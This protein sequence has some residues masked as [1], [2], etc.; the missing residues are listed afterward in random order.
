MSVGKGEDF[1]GEI[2]TSESSPD[3]AREIFSE[4]ELEVELR[5]IYWYQ[6][7]GPVS[8]Y[9]RMSKFSRYNIFFCC[10]SSLD[11]RVIARPERRPAC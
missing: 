5:F 7:I 10:C 3:F 2:G 11:F 1:T 6:F 8:R 9:N 4:D